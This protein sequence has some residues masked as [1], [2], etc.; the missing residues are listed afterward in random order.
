L[1]VLVVLVCAAGCRSTHAVAD[2]PAACTGDGATE[3]YT[4]KIEP[5]LKDDRPTSCNQC[6][7]SGIDLSIFV[8]DT[9]CQT[10]ACMNQLGLVNLAQ[11]AESKVL[12]WIDRAKPES[13][14]ITESVIQAEY[15]GMLEW[16]EYSSRCGGQVCPTFDDPCN[17][18]LPEAST[19]CDVSLAVGDG[20][21]DPGDCQERTLEQLFSAD[22][23]QWRERC[24]PCHFSSDSTVPQA[25]KWIS[26]V[27][28]EKAEAPLA[29]A[30][31]S[32]ATMRNV[33]RLGLVNLEQPGQSFLLL[34]PLSDEGGGITHGGGPKFDG[35]ADPSYQAFLA[36]IT[37]Y[38]ACTA[39]DPS[40]SKAGP[41]PPATPPTTDEAPGN[42][43]AGGTSSI[44]DY[45]NCMLFNCH[46]PSHAKWGQADEQLIAGCRAEA[47]NV[48]QHG[49]PTLSGNFLECRMAFCQQAR[50]N[51][52]ACVAAF[53]DTTCL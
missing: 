43:S 17:R 39:Q 46:D 29:C 2:P 11:P 27:D 34:K 37:R 7:L 21:V 49:A 41:P 36:W 19:R 26:D 22:V 4:R 35:P 16:I 15:E 1:S 20:Y 6:H 3:L 10:M 47:I 9:P 38:A 53:G 31:S 18:N 52:D 30:S 24:Y 42:T 13:T 48:P 51:P 12:A 25:P 8:K 14:L 32:L 40:L 23:Y 45:C 44:F 50:D 5:I 33:L 28:P